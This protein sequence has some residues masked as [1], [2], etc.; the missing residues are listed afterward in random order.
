MKTVC[1]VYD[2]LSA[3]VHEPEGVTLSLVANSRRA[4][5]LAAVVDRALPLR[6]ALIALARLVGDHAESHPARRMDPIVTVHP[7]AVLIEA[8]PPDCD[9]YAAIW[10]SMDEL[11][12]EGD[13]QYGTTTVDFAPWLRGALG[14][15]GSGRSTRVTIGVS[16]ACRIP[17][18]RCERRID[19][20]D[21]W[22]SKVNRMQAQSAEPGV[23]IDVRPVDLLRL[24]QELTKARPRKRALLR[25]SIDEARRVSVTVEPWNRTFHLGLARSEGVWG[26]HPIRAGR[27]L[28]VLDHVL[29]HATS[30]QL[31]VKEG[32][33]PAAFV[34]EMPGVRFLLDVPFSHDPWSIETAPVDRAMV[35][36]PPE[37]V[38]PVLTALAAR[39]AATVHEVAVDTSMDPVRVDRALRRLCHGGRAAFDVFT[40]TYRH[41]EL[42]ELPM[43]PESLE[44]VSAILSARALMADVALK[45]RSFTRRVRGQ[46]P[47]PDGLDECAWNDEMIEGRG[48]VGAETLRVLV[49]DGNI[50]E[51]SCSCGVRARNGARPCLH[52]LAAALFVSDAR[53]REGD[54]SGD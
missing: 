21:A 36:S 15:L 26:P 49:H 1:L 27:F 17:S 54:R 23:V 47:L 32:R 20:A 40:R 22:A 44:D 41:R 28:E 8:A 12:P 5:K 51:G 52:I 53:G 46:F 33:R 16:G 18:T 7:D 42:F 11:R 6:Q 25:L 35:E 45:L 48:S 37:L 29:P 3:V 9:A 4:V 30:T 13:V 10:L 43:D 50:V 39:R 24:L 34:V 14:E 31:I 38:A 2:S 19:H